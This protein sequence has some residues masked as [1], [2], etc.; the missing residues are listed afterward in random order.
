MPPTASRLGVRDA[1]AQQSVPGEA[2]A[3]RRL[4]IASRGQRLT[5]KS[6]PDTRGTRLTPLPAGDTRGHPHPSSPNTSQPPR[7]TW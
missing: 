3:S 1:G 2:A 4:A 7:A 6:H 5:L